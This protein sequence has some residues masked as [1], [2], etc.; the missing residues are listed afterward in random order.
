[1]PCSPGPCGAHNRVPN[2][3]LCGKVYVQCRRIAHQRAHNPCPTSRNAAHNTR[4]NVTLSR[5]AW[6]CSTM[7]LHEQEMQKQCPYSI[8]YSPPMEDDGFPNQ[9]Q[10]HYSTS[11]TWT[12]QERHLSI[13]VHVCHTP[14]LVPPLTVVAGPAATT[15]DAWL[16]R[17]ADAIPVPLPPTAFSQVLWAQ[18]AEAAS[19]TV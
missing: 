9:L 11:T 19:L 16:A 3:H 2:T 6:C 7:M 15:A 1:M 10:L 5:A 18:Q 17:G 4:H 8:L 14:H 13:N 12:R